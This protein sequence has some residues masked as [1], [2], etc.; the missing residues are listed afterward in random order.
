MSIESLRARIDAAGPV[1]TAMTT[2][3]A[4]QMIDDP[5]IGAGMLALPMSE[6]AVELHTR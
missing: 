3:V 5:Q 4:L 1:E 2:V 6:A